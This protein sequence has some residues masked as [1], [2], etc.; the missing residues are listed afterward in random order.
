VGKENNDMELTQGG[1]F[2]V[3]FLVLAALGLAIWALVRT[4]QTVEVKVSVSPVTALPPLVSP[5]VEERKGTNRD[6][7]F[8]PYSGIKHPD[9]FLTWDSLMAE[10]VTLTG[11]I[12]IFFDNLGV[13][14]AELTIPA[15]TYDMT[16][17]TWEAVGAI[18]AMNYTDHP[19]E[20]KEKRVTLH[21]EDGAIF[22]NLKKITGPFYITCNNTIPTTGTGSPNIVIDADTVGDKPSF[23]LSGG[24]VLVGNHEGTPNDF[25]FLQFKQ[26]AFGVL[27]L[28]NCQ[29]FHGIDNVAL[30]DIVGLADG[31]TEVHVVIAN[32]T[33]VGEDEFSC[34]A[35]AKL[36]F[37]TDGILPQHATLACLQYP[38]KRVGTKLALA[39]GTI[40]ATDVSKSSKMLPK[41]TVTTGGVTAPGSLSTLLLGTQ[42]I[43]VGDTYMTSASIVY[44]VAAVDATTGAITWTTA[45]NA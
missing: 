27:R 44:M 5:Y 8:A 22:T 34:T 12:T 41:A 16:N 28:D 45:L 2:S 24:A 37:F 23:E 20:N 13:S 6:L 35:N 31:T 1:M 43:K 7:V 21:L 36:K 14:E 18:P 26:V 19:A 4:Y 33:M 25:P 30:F 29:V 3:G 15:G 39:L 9:L 17:V 11:P 32:H 40:T 42:G 38:I 10:L